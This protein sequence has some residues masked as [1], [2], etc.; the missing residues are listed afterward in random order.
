MCVYIMQYVYVI[1]S[2]ILQSIGLTNYR[3][4]QWSVFMVD[5]ARTFSYQQS[6][7]E[8]FFLS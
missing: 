2:Y 1:F 3:G 5:P 4:E 8:F 6:S 7:E